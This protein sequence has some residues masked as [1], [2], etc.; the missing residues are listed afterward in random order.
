MTRP[1]QQLAVLL[2]G[3]PLAALLDDGTHGDLT[4]V[5]WNPTASRGPAYPGPRSSRRGR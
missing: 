5:V 1:A 3:H 2:L 4:N